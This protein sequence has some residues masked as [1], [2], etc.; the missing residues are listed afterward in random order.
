MLST[1]TSSRRQARP[2][3]GIPGTIY[4][5]KN[6]GL[7]DSV[8]QIGLSR[9][10]G[11]AKALELNR[12]KNNHIPGSYECV[13]ELRAQDGG[14]ALEAIFDALQSHKLGRREQDFFE[15]DQVL[16]IALIERLVS[17]ADLKLQRHYRQ[18][19]ELQEYLAKSD[20][21]KHPEVTSVVREGIFKKA[22]NW[23]S[24]VVN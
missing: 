17:E 16:A 10:S 19:A 23:M 1:A 14:G 11:W 2:L 12:D 4:V 20:E 15:I 9:R 21:R 24:E 6:S 7:R 18:E 8:L 5:L 22:L 13:F 3:H